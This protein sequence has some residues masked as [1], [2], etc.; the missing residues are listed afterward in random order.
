M[1]LIKVAVVGASGYSGA[2]LVRLLSNHPQVDLCAIG[3]R[4]WAGHKIADVHGHLAA[5]DLCFV[6]SKKLKWG[7]FD[8]VFFATPSG[9]AMRLAPQAIAAGTKVIDISA[10]FRLDDMALWETWYGQKHTAGDCLSQAVYGLCEFHA[11][12][13]KQAQLIANPG[14]YPTAILLSLLPLLKLDLIEAKGIKTSAISGLSGAGLQAKTDL[15]LTEASANVS[16]YAA[17]G[18]RHLPEM[19]QEMHLINPEIELDFVPHLAPMSRG[20]H[21]TSFVT[22]KSGVDAMQAQECLQNYYADSFFVDVQPLGMHP[23]S[24]D[25]YGSNMCRLAV[26]ATPNINQLVVLSV[27]D[28]LIKGAAGSAI[29]N[30]NLMFGLV[31]S[32]GLPYLGMRP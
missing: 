31:E 12:A 21:A 8:L 20:I 32:T 9:V 10:D 23:R 28:N 25:V 17:S 1:K 24:A 26:H 27:I 22:L 6:D 5:I 18:H 19:L 11:V 2:E 30:M 15:L 3:S 29:Q 14:C 13:I 16:A 7:D 4:Q